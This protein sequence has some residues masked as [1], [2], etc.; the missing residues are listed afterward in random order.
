MREASSLVVTV[1]GASLRAISMEING[2]ISH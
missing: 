1:A 2:L